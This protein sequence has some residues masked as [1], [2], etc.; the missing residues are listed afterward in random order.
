L[1][2][3]L[4]LLVIA[5]G[6]VLGSRGA[7]SPLVLAGLA[8]GVA[9]AA[10][11]FLLPDGLGFLGDALRYEVPKTVHYWLSTVAAA[12][13]AVAL[14]HAWS[15]ARLPL[16]ARAGALA[17]FVVV[18]ALPVRD[19]PI[20]AFHLG[21]HR[22]SETAAID[23]RWAGEG[24]WAGF[25]DSRTV[26]DAPRQEILDALR[27]EIDAGR[28]RHDTQVLH[29]ARSFQ[30]WLSTPLGVFDGVLETS[31]SLS[32]EVSHQTVGGRLLGSADPSELLQQLADLL[33]SGAYPYVVLEPAGLPDEARALVEGAGYGAVFDNEQ[34]AVFR[35]G[36]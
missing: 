14:A 25:P 18:A 36:G 13:A 10:T 26:V 19:Q 35:I 6:V 21:E 5:A 9:A 16:A 28:L 23:L 34:G 27:V 32:P 17:V 8:V 22:W 2:S 30:Q 11:A 3:G 15:G 29:V 31:I 33:A 12:G 1:S 24:F 7:R 20:N 4:L